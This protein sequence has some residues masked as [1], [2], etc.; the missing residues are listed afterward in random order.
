M[1]PHASFCQYF[2]DFKLVSSVF[3]LIHLVGQAI[4]A[5]LKVRVDPTLLSTALSSE[6]FLFIKVL[7]NVDPDVWYVKL[8]S[9]IIVRLAFLIRI[10][11]ITNIRGNQR[12]YDRNDSWTNRAFSQQLQLKF[13]NTKHL[14]LL[15]ICV[16]LD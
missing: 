10:V 2:H 15:F 7:L 16:A 8:N 14:I 12:P 3:V 13:L 1:H 6:S 4:L 5:K 11:R 9:Y